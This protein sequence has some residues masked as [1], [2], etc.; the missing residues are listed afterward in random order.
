MRAIAL[1][2]G[3]LLPVTVTA[4]GAG[5]GHPQGSQLAGRWEVVRVVTTSVGAGQTSCCDTMGPGAGLQ[6]I[7]FG[8]RSVTRDITA[9]GARLTTRERCRV[10]GCLIESRSL[11]WNQAGRGTVGWTT[12]AVDSDR[13]VLTV[14]EES[15]TGDAVSR[16]TRVELVRRDVGSRSGPRVA[17][18]D[19]GGSGGD[20]WPGKQGLR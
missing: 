13:L 3:V 1:L 20:G 15:A 4:A 9:G 16:E 14:H 8:R 12:C 19:E 18:T 7:S 10:R 11:A 6:T 5:D 17:L 2:I